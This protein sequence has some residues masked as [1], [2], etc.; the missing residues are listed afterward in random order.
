[1][2]RSVI[3][4]ELTKGATRLRVQ[5]FYYESPSEMVRRPSRHTLAL[6]SSRKK[7]S[8]GHFFN[9]HQADRLSDL[10]S[11]MFIPAGHSLFGMGPGGAQEMI[12]CSFEAGAIPALSPLERSWDLSDL[13]Q[14]YDIRSPRIS[15]TLRRITQEVLTPGFASDILIDA[16]INALPVELSRYFQ[17][18]P[19]TRAMQ[20]SK[21]GQLSQRQLQT[22]ED[23]VREWPAGGVRCE[24]LAALVGLSRAHFMRLFKATTGMTAHAFVEQLR[25]QQA[26]TL[27]ATTSMPLKQ[28]AGQLGFA[29]PASFS[30]AFRRLTGLT[31]GSYRAEYQ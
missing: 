5:T 16:L 1:M 29:T 24:D 28:I 13:T 31:P 9:R 21:R 15:D 22:I 12:A 7:S 30:L 14:C 19:E 10:G 18:H 8:R 2:K 27:L 3:Q 17:E 4:A 11:L 23:Y 25:L 6:M 26:Q 20:V